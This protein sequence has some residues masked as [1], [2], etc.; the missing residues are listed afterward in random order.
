MLIMQSSLGG[1]L[2]P[3]FM[4]VGW[5]SWCQGRRRCLLSHTFICH[6]CQLIHPFIHY[7]TVIAAV[8]VRLA[9][10]EACTSS[11]SHAHG[12]QALHDSCWCNAACRMLHP[13]PPPPL[14]P[15]ICVLC[16]RCPGGCISCRVLKSCRRAASYRLVLSQMIY[17]EESR[18]YSVWS[19]VEYP[20]SP[21]RERKLL[22]TRE[23]NTAQLLWAQLFI[24]WREWNFVIEKSVIIHVNWMKYCK[25]WGFYCGDYEECRLLGCYSA[26]L[27]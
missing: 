8:D 20:L 6:T 16:S 11:V 15:Y 18:G 17:Y 22:E 4:K 3:Q 1:L 25:I 14:P 21:V 24:M 23:L 26:W 19:N 12:S 2:T 7:R 13:N 27:L 9:R 10:Y 5:S